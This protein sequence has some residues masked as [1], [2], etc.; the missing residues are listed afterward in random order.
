MT[1]SSGYFLFLVGI[2]F[3]AHAMAQT[4]TQNIHCIDRIQ[5]F[6]V[7]DRNALAGA[8]WSNQ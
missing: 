3:K 5:A 7:S 2:G 6:D 8:M 1:E 4:I